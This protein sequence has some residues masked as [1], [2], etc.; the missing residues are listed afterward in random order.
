MIFEMCNL[1]KKSFATIAV[2]LLPYLAFPQKNVAQ[3]LE[4]LKTA[5]DST[6]TEIYYDIYQHYRY[7][8]PDSAYFYLGEGLRRFSA[9]DYKAGV[10]RITYLLANLDG[11]HG[12]LVMARKRQTESIRLFS[13]LGNEK[14]LGLA[15][16]GLGIVDGRQGNLDSATFHFIQAQKIFIRIG[17]DKGLINTYT[18]LGRINADTRN[19][20][21]A[22]EYYNKI[23]DIIPADGDP[24]VICNIYNNIAIVYG[25]QGDLIKAVDYLRKAL[26]KSDKEEH[27]DIYMFSLLNLGIVYSKFGDNKKA[28]ASLYEALAI[29][30][31][32][33][34]P[35]DYANI[36]LNIAPITAAGD[37]P[38]AIKQLEEALQ[39][40]QSVGS[41]E[42][43]KSIYTALAELNKKTGN[44]KA[45][46]DLMEQIKKYEDSTSSVEKVKEI[47]NLQSVY[48]LEQS[49]EKLK[50]LRLTQ[51]A[52]TLKRN[53]L[54][55]IL[56][57]L[58]VFIVLILLY[59]HRTKQLN[60][61]LAKQEV[62]LKASNMVKDRLFSIIGHDLRGPVGNITMILDMLDDEDTSP[63]ERRHIL[64][65]LSGHSR[66]TMETLD[67]LLIWGRS[68]I[69]EAG[70][71][72]EVFSPT[73]YL[74]KNMNL[75]ELSAK[76]K[77]LTLLNDLHIDVKLYGDPAHFDFIIRNL[78]SNAIKFTP[79]KGS[80]SISCDTQKIPGFVV[81]AIKDSG[82]GISKEDLSV[83]FVP[84][85]TNARGTAGEKGTGIGLTLSKE[86]VVENGGDMWVESELGK[87]ATF[88]FSFKAA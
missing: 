4:L 57:G 28:L 84:F 44:Y 64:Q 23:L 11:Q 45:V 39:V 65:S 58:A 88:Y 60:A 63:E 69:K 34:M 17:Y 22:L 7:F 40:A 21:K 41:K 9:E 81:Y 19:F 73:E 77:E 59:L 80:I 12:N 15:Y 52:N 55:T 49:T 54:Y 68:Q 13:E 16:N 86:F 18:N 48:E 36:L 50:E 31:E 14:G 2:L 25:E 66:S 53:I 74:Q 35:E 24:D 76:R 72:P 82:I 5:N 32:K 20:A 83:I 30:K 10:A 37:V 87:G 56:A 3:L 43:L 70:T 51:T 1:L 62:Q 75:L 33:Q 67:N 26:K 38:K 42:L 27:I 61:K 8:K 71:K 78:L 6:R 46:V 29:A 79:A 85:T 47:A